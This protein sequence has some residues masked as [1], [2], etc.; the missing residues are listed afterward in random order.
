TSDSGSEEWEFETLRDNKKGEYASGSE[1]LTLFVLTLAL[2]L[3][4]NFVSVFYFLPGFY[5]FFGGISMESFDNKH[6]KVVIST[7]L[8]WIRIVQVRALTEQTQSHA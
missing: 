6:R 2:K 3:T 1:C 8:I 7:T 5:Q 4:L